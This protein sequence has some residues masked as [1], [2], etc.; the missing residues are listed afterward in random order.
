M[1]SVL[2]RSAQ[3]SEAL[4]MSN[5]MFSYRNTGKKNIVLYL[6]NQNRQKKM[7][8]DMCLYICKTICQLHACPYTMSKLHVKEGH[9]SHNITQHFLKESGDLLSVEI[10][11]TKFQGPGSNSYHGIL[12]TRKV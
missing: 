9:N 10:S 8:L 11:S 4:L 6:E 7:K 1:L 12:L 2:N 5:H 3:A